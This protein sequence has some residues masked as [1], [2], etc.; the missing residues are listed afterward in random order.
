[1]MLDI[2][3]AAV[4]SLA[5]IVTHGPIGLDTSSV[6][7]ADYPM[8]LPSQ[9][10][11]RMRGVSSGNTPDV[12]I[13]IRTQRVGINVSIARPCTAWFQKGNVAVRS[14]ATP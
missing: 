1:M 10:T 13:A 8:I 3:L 12:A 14:A 11:K 7:V 4:S 9:M 6:H 2:H 5:Q